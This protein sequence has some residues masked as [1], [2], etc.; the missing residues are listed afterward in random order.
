MSSN[1][2]N[3]GPDQVVPSEQRYTHVIKGAVKTRVPDDFEANTKPVSVPSLLRT[4]AERW[5]DRSALCVKRDGRWQSTTFGEYYEQVRTA[6]RAFI[7]LGLQ[8]FDGVAIMGFNAP[9]YFVANMGAIMAGGVSTGMYTT[10]SSATCQFYL[11]NTNVTMVV[12]E[13]DKY[14]QRIL[15]VKDNCPQLKTIVQYTGRPA[16]AGVLSWEEFMASGASCDEALLAERLRGIAVN[17]CCSVIYT[18]GTVGQPKGV[19]ISH[20]IYT[21]TA[22]HGAACANYLDGED[23]MV[24]YL[25]L[26]HGAAQIVDMYACLRAGCTVYFAQPDAL[27]GSLIATL[28]EVRPTLFLGVPRIYEKMYEKFSAALSSGGLRM[29]LLNWCRAQASHYWSLKEKDIDT[30]V[31]WSLTVA[32]LMLRKVREKIGLDRVRHAGTSAAPISADVMA[33]VQSLNIPIFE[34]Y[35][36]SETCGPCT[37]NNHK[38]FKLGSIGREFIGCKVKILD[39]DEQGNGEILHW[40]RNIFMGYLGR[41]DATRETIDDDDWLRTGDVGRIDSDGYVH[42]T[43]RIKELLITAAGKNI[44]PVAIEEAIKSE[45]PL[46]S[47]CVVVG[48]R[49]K[50]LSALFTLKVEMDPDTGE[51]TDKLQPMAREWLADRGVQATTASGALKSLDQYRA[52]IQKGVSAANERAESHACWVQK[53]RLLSGEFSIP[54]G[55]LGPTLKMRRKVIMDKYRTEVEELYSG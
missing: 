15:E 27:K 24:S 41:E 2:Y 20:D 39:P 6:A 50:F 49:R 53:W 11:T 55:E 5:P 17:H 36:L 9:E 40:G 3:N 13:N 1:E 18:S 32:D 44:A 46:V 31:P 33:F 23:T 25:P 52:D 42:I 30:P 14:L 38:G 54:G 35:G 43:G 12:V 26:C 34:M 29:T 48:D 4:T 22:E 47:N 16:A 37:I 7:Q 8:P 45:L 28:C 51:A 21:W 10:S 19:M